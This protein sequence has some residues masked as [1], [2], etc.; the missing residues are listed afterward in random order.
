MNLFYNSGS[1]HVPGLWGFHRIGA[2]PEQP[3]FYKEVKKPHPCVGPEGNTQEY[4]S[5]NKERNDCSLHWKNLAWTPGYKVTLDHI[6]KANTTQEVNASLLFSPMILWINILSS[7]C[8]GATTQDPPGF[9]CPRQLF[10]QSYLNID[11]F[12][13]FRWT[14][15][16][17]LFKGYHL[18]WKTSKSERFSIKWTAVTE[19]V[20]L[21]EKKGGGGSYMLGWSCIVKNSKLQI[22]QSGWCQSSIYNPDLLS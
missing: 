9:W 12:F 6:F 10:W 5:W 8:L 19:W 1:D 13:H 15:G 17:R 14:K 21:E 2:R 18:W 20:F 22:L 11:S 16:G 7:S 4:P 3:H